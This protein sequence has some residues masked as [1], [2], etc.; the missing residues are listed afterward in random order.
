MDNAQQKHNKDAEIIL[1]AE[2]L[3]ETL[4]W[5][6]KSKK[7]PKKLPY[8]KFNIQEVRFIRDLIFRKP[9]GLL[10]FYLADHLMNNT[11]LRQ[12]PMFNAPSMKKLR[13]IHN[14]LSSKGSAKAA[15]IKAG[16]SPKTAKQQASRLLWEINGYK[17]RS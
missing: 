2:E 15:A 1:D 16:F 7:Y 3:I 9:K 5:L 17:R 12:L 6:L 13:F 10:F 4:V 11:T 8:P 14:F